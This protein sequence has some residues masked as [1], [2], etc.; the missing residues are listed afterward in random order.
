MADIKCSGFGGQGVLTAGLILAQVAMDKGLEVSW[1]PSYGSEMRGGLATCN[2]RI[3]NNRIG[4]PF[5]RHMDLLVAMNENSVNL[6]EEFIT[7]HGTLVVNSSLMPANY[8]YRNDIRVIEI[9][10]NDLAAQAENPRGVNMVM[11]AAAVAGKQ[12]FDEKHF[13]SSVEGFFSKKGKINPKNALC[14]NLGWKA[15]HTALG[16]K[17]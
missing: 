4:S 8:K 7:P 16:G 17:V 12:L 11:L 2:I 15:A 6:F 9:P 3:S 14:V 13:I 1:I 10:A 5:V